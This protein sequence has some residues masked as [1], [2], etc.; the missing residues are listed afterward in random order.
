MVKRPLLFNRNNQLLTFEPICRKQCF[1]DSRQT[2]VNFA[3]SSWWVPWRNFLDWPG[4]VAYPPMGITQGNLLLYFSCHNH[5][6]V[7][8]MK[9]VSDLDRLSMATQGL[10]QWET[11]LHMWR[12]L[13]FSHR[14]RLDQAEIAYRNSHS[15]SLKN[16]LYTFSIR[17][18]VKIETN[19]I[20]HHIAL[21]FKF[22]WW[23]HQMETF[24]ALLA[25][26]AGNSPVPVI[27]PHKGQWRG[28][29]M[30]SL[31]YAWINDWVNNREAGD[32]R[33]QRGHC[34]VIVM[35]IKKNVII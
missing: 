30:F 27:S 2:G 16:V 28:A 14:L 18:Y 33:R 3:N 12:R 21:I 34:D 15:L 23:R 9:Y 1:F 6:Y 7:T 25:L 29:L 31:I 13:S 19:T 10:N 26:C 20:F 22:S 5:W 4:R 24:S 8:N 35:C 17:Q 32:L 11:I